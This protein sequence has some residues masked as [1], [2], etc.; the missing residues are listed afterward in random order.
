MCADADVSKRVCARVLSCRMVITTYVR[1]VPNMYVAHARREILDEAIGACCR[2]HRTI[3]LR[4]DK[5]VNGRMTKYITAI[6]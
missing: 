6:I 2:L 4:D 3:T 5:K 1:T